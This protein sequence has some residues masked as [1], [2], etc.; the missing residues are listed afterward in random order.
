MEVSHVWCVWCGV[1]CESRCV[2]YLM[3]NLYTIYKGNIR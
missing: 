3:C 2:V 1:I